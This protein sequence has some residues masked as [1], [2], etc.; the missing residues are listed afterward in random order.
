MPRCPGGGVHRRSV[1]CLRAARPSW[2]ADGFVESSPMKSRLAE[3]AEPSRPSTIRRRRRAA[4]I[5]GFQHS[6]SW[7]QCVRRVALSSGQNRSAKSGR[8]ATF[9]ARTGARTPRPSIAENQ[10][11]PQWRPAAVEAAQDTTKIAIGGRRRIRCPRTTTLEAGTAKTA[12]N[13]RWKRVQ[14]P[15]AGRRARNHLNDRLHERGEGLV[16]RRGSM[17]ARGDGCSGGR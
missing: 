9:T 7:S 10:R 11:Q 14:R 4:G 15:N 2:M 12:P 1:G 8:S 13:D 16:R 3:P 6:T 5:A 17:D